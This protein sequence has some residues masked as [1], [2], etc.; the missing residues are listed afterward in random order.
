MDEAAVYSASAAVHL[1]ECTCRTTPTPA[2]SGCVVPILG[3]RRFHAVVIGP[4][5]G[6]VATS[7]DRCKDFH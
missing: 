6:A 1:C 4:G 5:F 7:T 3:G 2:H